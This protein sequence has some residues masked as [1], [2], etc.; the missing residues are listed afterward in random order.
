MIKQSIALLLILAAACSLSSCREQPYRLVTEES[1]AGWAYRISYKGRPVIYQAHI[2][3]VP[4]F[5]PFRTQSDAR[6]TG[7]LVLQK[8]KGGSIPSLS[9]HE[10][11][12]L[13]LTW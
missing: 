13:Q 6:R 8:L 11:D 12:S 2:P 3:A 1:S 5:H 4:G 7:T 10:I 9:L